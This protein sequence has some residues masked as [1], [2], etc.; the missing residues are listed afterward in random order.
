MMTRISNRD[1]EA[2]SA[3]L[4][5]QLSKRDQDRLEAR[6]NDNADLQDA[7]EQL[8][9]TRT[10]LRSLPVVRAPRNFMLTPQMVRSRPAPSPAYPVFRFASAIA[11]IFLALVLLGDFITPPATATLPTS[12]AMLAQEAPSAKVSSGESPLAATGAPETMLQAPSIDT[13]A[14]DSVQATESARQ[15]AAPSGMGSAG[16]EGTPPI[17]GLMVAQP[18]P[19]D[20]SG[21][22]QAQAVTATP[23]I[24]SALPAEPAAGEAANAAE[25]QA[26]DR[27]GEQAET[28]QASPFNLLRWLEVSLAAVA[29][30]TGL[31]A[32]YLRRKARG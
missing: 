17:A 26:F 4:D 10:V 21:T 22:F 27:A 13:A 6:L 15:T 20:A 19:A 32:V 24:V 7:L 30:V 12:A 3:Y 16:P 9:R 25:A 11:T 18:T 2:L 14:P 28:A 8:R 23:E 31:V 5:G 1:W 29:L